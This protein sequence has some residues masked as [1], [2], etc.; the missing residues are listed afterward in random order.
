METEFTNRCIIMF[1]WKKL[2]LST[3]N[4]SF[5]AET[6]FNYYNWF[7]R[8][9]HMVIHDVECMLFIVWQYRDFR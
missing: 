5:V 7:Q 2:G 8:P 6:D 4:I 9:K 1:K 3:I